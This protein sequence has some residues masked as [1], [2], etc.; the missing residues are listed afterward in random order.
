MKTLRNIFLC[1]LV[2]CLVLCGCK[3][4]EDPPVPQTDPQG[5]PAAVARPDSTPQPTKPPRET[6]VP[7]ETPAPTPAPEDVLLSQMTLEEKVAQMFFVRCPETGTAEY[8]GTRQPGGILLF[9]RDLSGLSETE[10]Q[11]KTAAMQ[12]AAKYGLLIGADEEGGTVVRVSSNPQLTDEPYWS[13]RKLHA[14]GGTEL[15]CSVEADKCDRLK[16]LGINVNFAPVCD[17]T[18]DGFMYA[19][20][21]GLSPE[22]TADVIG[23]MVLVYRSRRVGC[24]LKHFPGYGNAAD[25]H[26]GIAYDERPIETFRTADFLPFSTGIEAGAGC[27]L[28]AH[29]IVTCVDAQ[30]PASLSPAWHDLLRDELGFDGVIITDDL[31]MGAIQD[32]TDGASAAVTA[33]L[34]GNDMLCCSAFQSQ[35]DAVLAAVQDG[36]IAE[37]RIDESVRRI[38]RWKLDLGLIE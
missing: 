12:A 23:E 20:S 1:T 31:A 24:V 6:P 15:V 30:V 16:S 19:R 13:P 18:T 5:R 14:S 4:A 26:H 10:V 33:V 28:V 27:V 38:L 8:V 25:T 7:T 36:T 11:E 32:Y 3:T 21:L 29:N 2:L 37:S 35:Y 34:A 17:I 9:G 22:D